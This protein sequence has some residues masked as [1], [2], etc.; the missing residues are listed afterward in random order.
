MFVAASIAPSMVNAQT[1]LADP[2]KLVGNPAP[3]FS[4]TDT[5]GK[6]HSLKDYKGKLVVLE[7]I[8]FD[9]PF[10]KKHYSSSNM[11]TLQNEYTGKG[12]VWMTVNSSQPGK[13][14]NYPPEKINEM[15]KERG[16]SPT[17]YLIDVDGK[18]G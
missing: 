7:W 9:C 1:T 10:V 15:I 2:E 16:A 8:N 4:L 11:Q 12:I 14:G 18:V 6:Q 5:N 3:E 13:Q 17:A